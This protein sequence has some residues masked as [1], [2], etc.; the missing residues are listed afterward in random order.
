MIYYDVETK[1]FIYK[2]SQLNTQEIITTLTTSCIKRL[3]GL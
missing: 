3:E 2:K 1:E